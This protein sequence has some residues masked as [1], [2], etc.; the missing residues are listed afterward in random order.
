MKRTCPL[1][2]ERELQVTRGD[3]GKA[4]SARCEGCGHTYPYATETI[5]RVGKARIT[6]RELLLGD[7][8]ATYSTK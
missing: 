6:R 8:T 3:N 7:G 2:N 5:E 1:C 4:V